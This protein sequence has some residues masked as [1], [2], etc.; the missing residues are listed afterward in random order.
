MKKLI[1]TLAALAVC[2]GAFA[3]EGMWCINAINSALEKNMRARGLKLKARQIYDA[4]APGAQLSDAVVSLDFGCTGSIISAEGLLITNHHCAYSDIHSL[5]TEQNNYLEDGFYARSEAEEIHIKGKGAYFLKQVLD[6]TDE[7]NNLRD[8]LVAAGKPA[9]GRRISSL[10]EKAYSRNGLEAGLYSMWSGSKYYIALYKVY[11]DV[12]LVAAP[13]VC[14]AAFGADI[15]NWEWPQ[16]KCDF[17]VYRVYCAPDGEPAEYSPFNVPLESEGQLKVSRKGYK[18]GDYAMVIGYPGRTN[19]YSSSA[20]NRLDQTVKNPIANKLRGQQMSIITEW[21]EA[22]PAVRLKYANYFFSLSNVQELY[23]GEVECIDRFRVIETKQEQEKE[24]QEWIER[25]GKA[26]KDLLKRLDKTYQAVVDA[27][28]NTCYYRETLIRGTRMGRIVNAINNLKTDVM[29]KRGIRTKRG[30]DPG[31]VEAQEQCYNC[32]TFVGKDFDN[33]G[34]KLDKEYSQIDLRVEKDLFSYAVKEYYSNVDRSFWGQYQTTL[35]DSYGTDKSGCE[36]IAGH[37][38]DGSF[39]TD[40]ARK[41]SFLSEE[42]SLCEMCSDPLVRFFKDVQI[43]SFNQ[44]ISDAEGDENLLNLDKEY[45]RALYN[46][47]NDRGVLQYPDANSSMR[48][49]YG[50]IGPLDSKDAVRCSHQTTVKGILE[51]YRPAIYDFSLKDPLPGLYAGIESM[52]VDFI[53]DCDITGGNSGSPVMNARGELIG[54]AFDGNKESLAEDVY[55]TPGYN[56]CVCVD[57]RFVLWIMEHYMGADRLLS[58]INF[59]D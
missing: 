59:A 41:D 50:T 15:D 58:E 20:K 13:P 36:A 23:S 44:A 42:H 3:D 57:I 1:L 32:Y 19:R 18:C 10:M 47:R 55:Y 39:L 43:L 48:L 17:A 27:Q 25:S 4:D 34:E 31:D 22:D 51:K 38:W 54:L 35:A 16:H 37:I 46:M 49:T 29:Q 21:M 14:V 53:C 52:P 30:N 8:S 33:L 2:T 5:C 9:G 56:K 12:R 28:R 40:T 11:K 7:V 26:D 45:T 24:L 6:V